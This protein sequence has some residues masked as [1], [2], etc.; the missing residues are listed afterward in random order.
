MHATAAEQSAAPNVKAT[1]QDLL[2]SIDFSPQPHAGARGPNGRFAKVLLAV[3]PDGDVAG[4]AIY[5]LTFAA[6]LGRTGVCLEDLFV[7]PEHRRSGYARDL[8]QA[9]AREAN[10]LGCERMEWQCYKDNAR[11][12]QFYK[13]LGA[14][15]L[16]PITYLRL[17][18]EGMV[19][20]AE[21]EV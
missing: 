12:L 17:D 8:V 21:D 6:W 15:V 2:D 18:K 19:K 13:S 20:L 3:S 7:A 10:D 5:F 4:M 9:I 16:E 14:K 11:A 1:E